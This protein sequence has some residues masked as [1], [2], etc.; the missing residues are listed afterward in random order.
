MI[1]HGFCTFQIPLNL[2]D[3][4]WHFKKQNVTEEFYIP[5]NLVLIVV[6][7]LRLTRNLYSL[8]ERVLTGAQKRGR[9][10][11][12]FIGRYLL[13]T[14]R[15]FGKQV[16]STKGNSKVRL[17]DSIDKLCLLHGVVCLFVCFLHRALVA[18]SAPR[19]NPAI[20]CLPIASSLPLLEVSFQNQLGSLG[21]SGSIN[22][23]QG[24]Q[25]LVSFI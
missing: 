24:P 9:W 22:S 20:C 2:W 6:T 17:K 1:S 4:C 18:A 13:H 23:A 25:G 10:I 16:K 7:G 19:E 21:T 3:Q 8:K 5:N 11:W 15:S 12:E 14:Q